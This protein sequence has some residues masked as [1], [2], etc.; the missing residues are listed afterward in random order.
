[1]NSSASDTRTAVYTGSFDPI[2]LG[3]LNVIERASRLFDRIIVGVGINADKVGLFTPDE[4]VLLVEKATQDLPRV[5]VRQFVGLAVDFVRQC[6]ARI[7]IRGV[8]PLTDAAAEFTLMLAN[9]ELAPDIETV[10]LMADEQLA[11]VSSSLIKEI[12][13]LASDEMMGRFL[14]AEV[15]PL[16]RTKL[17]ANQRPPDA[18][19]PT[20]G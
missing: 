11:H 1:M 12:A 19:G 16:L 15:I 2:T 4:R 3:H 20:A 13:P 17:P 8:R 14:P 10:F 7:M 9:R 5:H 18:Q 6:N